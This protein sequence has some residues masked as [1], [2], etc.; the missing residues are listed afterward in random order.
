VGRGQVL[1]DGRD[2]A[3]LAIGKMVAVAVIAAE[4]LAATGVSVTVVDARFAKPIDPD[5]PAL[6][7]RHR[8]ALT[9]EDGTARGGFG[10]GVLEA[11]ADAGVSVPV[12]VLGLPD[13]FIEHGQQA[14]LL[15]D[16]GLDADGVVEAARALLHRDA[17]SALA[18]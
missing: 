10:S 9:L 16:F 7:E 6:V 3:L 4:K 1:R 17:E 5:L 12:R 13:A 2:I 11:L 18:G 8:A 15:S 14:R